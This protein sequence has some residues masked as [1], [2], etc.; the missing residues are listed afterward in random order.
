[1][2]ASQIEHKSACGALHLRLRDG[3]YQSK[4]FPDYL[5]QLSRMLALLAAGVI[6]LICFQ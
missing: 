3:E 6:A 2:L 4:A 5:D 1:M